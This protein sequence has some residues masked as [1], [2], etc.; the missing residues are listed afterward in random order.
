LHLTRSGLV[1]V[2][3][4][5][6]GPPV[7]LVPGLAGG[8]QLLSPLARRLARSHEVILYNL[9][10]DRDGSMRRRTLT[11]HAHDLADLIGELRLERPTVFGV[12]FGGAI[13]LELAVEMPH[14]AGS[15]ILFGAE[16]RFRAGLGYSILRNVL[17]RY[18]LPSDSPFFNQ[19]FN[20]LHG[21]RPESA[22]LA[23]F[24][25]R[26]CWT[27]DQSVMVHRLRA[28]DGFDVTDRLWRVDVPSLVLAGARDVVV[29]PP[30]QHALAHG[31][32]G[33]HFATIE[34][35]GHVGF[36]TH[37]GEVSREV[38]RMLR[39]VHRSAL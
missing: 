13:A 21:G 29:P 36:L 33:C 35:A 8:W 24:V 3:R 10:G 25:V 28:L 5:G 14:V 11:D 22:E 20:I 15:L 39:A 16:A 37:A 27:T 23:E 4:A 9:A 7:V 1:E 38:R 19:F 34:G 30:R 17:E 12:S 31:I 2:V 32:P 6:E 18:E 26:Q